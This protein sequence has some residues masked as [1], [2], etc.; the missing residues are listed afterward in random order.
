MGLNPRHLIL[1]LIII[2]PRH[3]YLPIVLVIFQVRKLF[4]E[5]LLYVVYLFEVFGAWL[6]VG[7]LID[8]VEAVQSVESGLEG[9]FRVMI[10]VYL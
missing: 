5:C 1:Q 9:L 4:D 6:V 3:L 7:F 10:D 8:P 2:K